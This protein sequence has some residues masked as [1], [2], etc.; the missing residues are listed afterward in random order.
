MKKLNLKFSACILALGLVLQSAVQGQSIWLEGWQSSPV[1]SYIPNENNLVLIPGDKGNW[2]VGD[3]VSEDLEEC[4]PNLNKADIIHNGANKVLKLTA[5]T[6]DGGCANNIWVALDNRISPVLIPISPNTRISFSESGLI[7]NPQW[8]GAFPT[9]T[10]PPADSIYLMLG[11]N[12][13]NRLHYLFHR[14]PNYI[15]HSTLL[16]AVTE[17]GGQPV[18]IGYHEIFLDPNG[19]TFNRNLY[20]DFQEVPNFNPNG[21]T[22]NQIIFQ[23][24]ETGFATLD[25]LRIGEFAPPTRVTV[26]NV[27]GMSEEAAKRTIG[28]G[29]LLV[30]ITRFENSNS[31]PEGNVID[32]DPIGGTEVDEGSAIDLVISSGPVIPVPDIVGL[33]QAE[34]EATLIAAT[35]TIGNV[36]ED[37][38]DSILKGI[39]ISQNP[40][41]GAERSSG[42]PI[43]F[44]IS[45]GPVPPPE[46]VVNSIGD[47][48]DIN[49]GDGAC[50]TQRGDGECSFRA[51][52]QEANALTGLHK[53][54]FNIPG[55]GPHTIQPLSE[56]PAITDPVIIDGYTQGNAS[57]N[58]LEIGCNANL[59][60]E[61]DGTM[62]G[63]TSR[64]LLV[65]GG[66]SLISGLVINRFGGP[67]IHLVN[68]GKNRV[69]GNFIGSDVSGKIDLGNSGSG[70]D[71]SSSH[72][73]TIGGLTPEHR[74]IIASNGF[75]GISIQNSDRVIIQGNY[76]GTDC[77]GTNN[78][79]NGSNGILLGVTAASIVG[80]ES[81]G[82]KNVISGNALFG[83]D[84]SSSAR[85]C[86][87]Q[88][89]FIGTDVSG[90]FE[91]GNRSGMAIAGGDNRI[92]DNLISANQDIGIQI[93]GF[94]Q[95][96]GTSGNQIQTNIIGADINQSKPLGNGSHGILFRIGSS[97][98]FPPVNNLI[99]G[100]LDSLGN[101]ITHNQG[102]GILLID[103]TGNFIQSNSIHSNQGLGIDLGTLGVSDNDAGDNDIGPNELINFPDLTVAISRQTSTFLI[104]KLDST[105]EQNFTIQYFANDACDPSG[106]GEGQSLIGTLQIETNKSGTAVFEVEIPESIAVGQFI[107]AT[108]V[109][110]NGNTSEFSECIQVSASNLVKVP[111]LVNQPSTDIQ[112]LLTLA[113]LRVGSIVSENNSEV[114][115]GSVI[116]QTPAF[117]L[118]LDFRG[119][120][121]LVISSSDVITLEKGWNLI[122]VTRPLTLDSFTPI[123]RKQFAETLWS[124]QNGRFHVAMEFSPNKGY[125]VY[126][127]SQ[128]HWVFPNP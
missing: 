48:D 55:E 19:G 56:L 35:L 64:G 124:F 40:N 54:A 127:F 47:N 109:D 59:M 107:T 34:A 46:I 24:S 110:A 68:V 88:G 52:I 114:P 73:N 121:N 50:V 86:T 22:I 123:P 78:L 98:G 29:N 90:S 69:Q 33:S 80:G 9:F 21:S 2:F 106:H 63:G 13:G 74:N 3:T 122:S 126:G 41:P 60:I 102:A 95:E 77:T 75:V 103:G 10:P 115:A 23:I 125:W 15:P 113:G 71:M 119:T 97:P 8:N 53:I 84:L 27:V 26:P 112:D 79:G 17:P 14:A 99:G 87:V 120:V 128:S 116:R 42:D 38:H 4:G 92:L 62:A 65:T 58:S 11:D 76:I 61:L 96:N 105:A 25:D 12:N 30:G 111:D 72:D 6:N 1:Q 57:P 118:D 66:D 37:H 70:I 20:D 28:N 36:T 45:L 101:V 82:A 43:D 100:E 104:G 31:V 49:P 7:D 91:I 93:D 67:G 16:D 5:G 39:V 32:Q 81:G 108:S 89:N 117:N 85:N 51:A 94:T 44:V 83:V 18:K